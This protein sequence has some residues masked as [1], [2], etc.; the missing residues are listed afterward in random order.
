MYAIQPG[1]K[2]SRGGNNPQSMSARILL[3]T[4]TREILVQARPLFKTKVN[5]GEQSSL[6]TRLR[7]ALS[8]CSRFSPRKEQRSGFSFRFPCDI[9]FFSFRE[10]WVGRI[11]RLSGRRYRVVFRACR[12]AVRTAQRAPATRHTALRALLHPRP[13]L[14]R[15]PRPITAR[16]KARATFKS[17]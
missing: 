11:C 10:S 16:G 14:P 17:A 1:S 6:L 15:A 3:C 8:Y 4:Q 5:L 2:I 12:S 7:R 13:P 9:I